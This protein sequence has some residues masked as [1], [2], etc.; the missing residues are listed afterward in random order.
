MLTAAGALVLILGLFCLF[1]PADLSFR[2]LL[3]LTAFGAIAAVALPSGS[4]ILPGSL[5]LLSV[6]GRLALLEKSDRPF[7]AEI[8]PGRPGFWLA[9][10]VVYGLLVSVFVPRIFAGATNVFLVGLYNYP[11]P[12]GPSA[13]HVTQGIYAIGDLMAFMAGAAILRRGEAVNTVLSAAAWAAGLIAF[14]GVL[15]LVS[16]YGGFPDIMNP[17]HTAGYKMLNSYEFAGLKRVAGSYSESSVFVLNASMVYA[18]SFHLWLSGIRRIVFG[19]LTAV[20]LVLLLIST[21]ATAYAFV[22]CHFAL[23]AF[24][25]LKEVVVNRRIGRA[26]ILSVAAYLAAMVGL[27]VMVSSTTIVAAIQAFLDSVLFTKA[28]SDSGRERSLI[29]DQAIRNLFE[30]WLLGVGIGGARASG[31]VTVLLSNVGVAGFCLFL[32]FVGSILLTGNGARASGR[33]EVVAQASKFA[34]LSGLMAAVV[35]LTFF[36]IGLSFYL[37]AAAAAVLSA[38]PDRLRR[39][40]P[41]GYRRTDPAVRPKD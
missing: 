15:D 19:P 35:S 31:Y 41:T 14:F 12:L 9:G 25:V 8:A 33:R 28:L 17:L 7:I 2:V 37:F 4:T 16:F 11:V 36:E 39:P 20:L 1:R 22:A 30:T 40:P 38:N 6:V 27:V 29:A 5:F 13:G 23:V 32:L 21:S 24:F 3:A 10:L 18:F 34:M 26:V